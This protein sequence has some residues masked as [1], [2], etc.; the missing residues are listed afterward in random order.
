VLTKYPAQVTDFYTADLIFWLRHDEMDRLT[1]NGGPC[2][3]LG[4]HSYH[5]IVKKSLHKPQ[6]DKQNR[7]AQLSVA[8]E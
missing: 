4:S 5:R 6:N 2:A 1:F 8:A 7:H 3:R